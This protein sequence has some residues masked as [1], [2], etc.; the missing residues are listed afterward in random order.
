[1]TLPES[2][3][4]LLRDAIR[5]EFAGTISRWY[6]AHPEDLKNAER[7][8]ESSEEMLRLMMHVLAVVDGFTIT[9]RRE[10]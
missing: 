8:K 7:L 9:A 1:M 2:P 3:E 5:N 4:Q 10:K 6:G